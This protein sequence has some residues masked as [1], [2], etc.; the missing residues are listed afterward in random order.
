MP[1]VG[2]VRGS[3]GGREGCRRGRT[4]CGR[5]AMVVWVGRWGHL[6]D[7]WAL[8]RG[9]APALGE[10]LREGSGPRL[11]EGLG[12][13]LGLGL[14]CRLRL[15]IRLGDPNL[16]SSPNLVERRAGALLDDVPVEGGAAQAR[17]R[18]LVRDELPQD[19]REGIEL[20]ARAVGL[21]V[22]HLWGGRSRAAWLVTMARWHVRQCPEPQSWRSAASPRQPLGGGAIRGYKGPASS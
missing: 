22:A 8:R 15:G 9:G 13:G 20:R 3:E 21:R 18:H 17:V 14:G 2:S 6:L 5:V 16:N 19:D 4:G 1:R 11:V 10:Q 7:R 12:L